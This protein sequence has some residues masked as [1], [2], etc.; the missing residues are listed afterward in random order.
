MN[1]TSSASSG[2]VVNYF[3]CEQCAFR[4]PSYR[5]CTSFGRWKASQKVLRGGSHP[6]RFPTTAPHST[7]ELHRIVHDSTES[8]LEN[9]TKTAQKANNHSVQIDI[10][11]GRDR[12]IRVGTKRGVNGNRHTER[13]DPSTGSGHRLHHSRNDRRCGSFGNHHPASHSAH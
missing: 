6:N 10:H 13:A 11:W 1:F 3:P 9:I 2:D 4:A 8:Y 7:T 12:F 5:G